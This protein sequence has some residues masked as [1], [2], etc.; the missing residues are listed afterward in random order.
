[1]RITVDLSS[2]DNDVELVGLGPGETAEGRFG[3]RGYIAYR[4]F[5]A[6]AR[7]LFLAIQKSDKPDI[8]AATAMQI[9]REGTFIRQRLDELRGTGKQ[10]GSRR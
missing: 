3:V 2:P 8:V 1:M 6:A 9:E 5:N 4:L 7:L 10:N